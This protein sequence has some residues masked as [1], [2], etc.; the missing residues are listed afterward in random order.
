MGKWHSWTARRNSLCQN[1]QVIVED[2]GVECSQVLQVWLPWREL[3]SWQSRRFPRLRHAPISC[4]CRARRS[5]WTF[6]RVSSR[7]L[8]RRTIA[9]T[10]VAARFPVTSASRRFMARDVTR[11]AQRESRGSLVTSLAISLCLCR[12]SSGPIYT[13]LLCTPRTL[14]VRSQA[15][16]SR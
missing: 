9:L 10:V 13:A 3:L 5:E 8:A 6:R 16:S 2:G 1:R 15:L 4:L 11:L 12:A 14:G 7:A